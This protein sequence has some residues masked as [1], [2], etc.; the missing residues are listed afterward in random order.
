MRHFVQGH[1]STQ[2]LSDDQLRVH[3]TQNG[4]TIPGRTLITFTVLAIVL[5]IIIK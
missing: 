4:I 5:I 3:A 2:P 1:D